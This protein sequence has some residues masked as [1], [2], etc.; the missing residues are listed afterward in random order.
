MKEKIKLCRFNL[1]KKLNKDKGTFS[2]NANYMSFE[3]MPNFTL[4]V[5]A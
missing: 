3:L 2:K 5:C 1:L 4:K